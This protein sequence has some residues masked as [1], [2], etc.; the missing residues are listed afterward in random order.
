[1]GVGAVEN[2]QSPILE[3]DTPMLFRCRLKGKLEQRRR[4][5]GIPGLD[6]RDAW[7]GFM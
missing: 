6:S 5:P 3:S 2:I 1:M 4:Q 7:R